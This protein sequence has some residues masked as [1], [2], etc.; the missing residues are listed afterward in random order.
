LAAAEQQQRR[1]KWQ[2]NGTGRFYN[3][4]WKGKRKMLYSCA[5]LDSLDPSLARYL[6][7][8]VPQSA[9]FSDETH[10]FHYTKD[11]RAVQ[12][13]GIHTLLKALFYSH[14]QSNRSQRDHARVNVVGS[15]AAQGQLVDAQLDL[16]VEGR[17]PPAKQK[18]HRMTLALL[19]FWKARGHTLQ[20]TQVPVELANGW[21]RM[22][23]AD[24]ITRCE[25][26][27]KLWLWEIKTGYPIGFYRKQKWFR[28]APLLDVPC[29]QENIWFLQLHYT[30]QALH[31]SAGVRIEGG[32]RILQVYAKKGEKQLHVEERAPPEWLTSRVPL[33]APPLG[34]P[35]PRKRPA[36]EPTT[37]REK[38]WKDR[39]STK[40]LK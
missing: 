38:E 8:E 28:S 7:S 31:T 5:S 35:V 29:T 34:V 4:N 13:G 22:T 14:Y 15:S 16:A 27:G 9:R 24:V 11:Q 23:K 17:E 1:S 12:C 21:G 40:K 25:A 32:A 3:G 20:A 37:V 10:C 18:W 6:H 33:W 26:D 2:V 30:H 39:W 36:T 19:E